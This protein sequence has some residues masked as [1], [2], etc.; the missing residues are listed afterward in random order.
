MYKLIKIFFVIPFILFF[1]FSVAQNKNDK[2]DIIVIDAGHG[3]KDPGALG[4]KSK[5][6]DITLAI[7]LKTGK[8]IKENLPGVKVVY[9]RKTDKFIELHERSATA[10]RNNADLFISIHVNA[11]RNKSIAGTSTFVMGLNKSDKQLDV[12]KRENSVILIED[13]YKTKYEGFDPDSPES[14][15]IFSLYQNAYLEKS[16][17]LA[18]L[19]QEEFKDRA[20]RESRDVRQAGLVVLW[21]CS[22][23][24]ILIETGFISNPDEENFL[25]SE[26]GQA[27]IAS[28]VYRA[29]K[30]YKS[31]IEHQNIIKEK[32]V[33]FKVQ[34][35]YSSKKIETKP[36]NFKGIKNVECIEDG[37]Y[38]RYFTGK[39]K[40]YEEIAKL[41]KEIRK[42]IPEAYIIAVNNGKLITVKEAMQILNN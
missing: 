1:Y 6:K 22:M 34:I 32:N 19:V 14:D 5:E 13:N 26:K 37:R 2:V 33:T 41:Q 4:K 42:K 25:N 28:A 17:R 10:N 30:K 12:V 24:S 23:P 11:S 29:V 38:F 31:E 21:N 18:E 8:Y 27:I 9:T 36:E 15:I 3:G 7:A 40:S 39:S 20:K 35:A 16:I